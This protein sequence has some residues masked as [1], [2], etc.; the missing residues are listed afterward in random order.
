MIKK[1]TGVILLLIMLCCSILLS[2]TY[3][4]YLLSKSVNGQIELFSNCEDRGIT[5][6]AE[7]LILRDTSA[8]GNNVEA[9]KL[10]IS[11]KKTSLD[12]TA[13]DATIPAIAPQTKYVKTVKNVVN[14]EGIFSS[15]Y[16]Y[17]FSSGYTFD[18][19]TGMYTL[20][21]GYVMDYLDSKYIGYYT[22]APNAS[23]S[24]KCSEMYQVKNFEIV[25][26]SVNTIYK[27]TEADVYSY[28]T[29]ELFSSDQGL[30]ATEDNY[31]TSYY[32]RGAVDNNYVSYAGFIWKIV[33]INGD[34]S[35][36]LI[37]N[38]NSTSS[39]GVDTGIAATYFS[40]VIDDPTYVGYMYG[41]D[42]ALKE[43][44][45]ENEKSNF[46]SASQTTLYYFADSYEFDSSTEKF[47]LAGNFF[48]GT[49]PDNYEKIISDYPYTCLSLS[50]SGKCNFVVKALEYVS[51][52][53]MK[54]NYVS[55]SSKSYDS[56][57]TNTNDS[58]IKTVID[59]WYEN[60]ILN[61]KDSNDNSYSN[62]LNDTIFCNDRSLYSGDGYSLHFATVYGVRNRTGSTIYKASPS[63]ICS[64]FADKF[65]V[66]SSSGNGA[67]SYPIGLISADEAMFA[68]GLP[69]VVNENYYLNNGVTNYTMT[70]FRFYPQ[71]VGAAIMS[72]HG[73]GRVGSGLARVTRNVRPVINL[74]SDVKIISGDGMAANPF[75]ISIN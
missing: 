24:I 16:K 45:S 67:L 27:L 42:F 19:Y 59:S 75:I 54:A 58:Y 21:S 37:Y 31:G 18:E 5:N 41:K 44:F 71:Y 8:N 35:I 20:N 50:K 23:V 49:W 7:C 17:T 36:R 28:K 29:T 61:V 9:A 55:Y 48:R 70:P 2:K 62:Y 51:N 4:K 53:T 6:L 1:F 38:G 69:N 26:S 65:T 13:D 3:S 39:T 15:T 73:D 14:S 40:D 60:N 72:I 52:G 34:G 57:L 32:Y 22:C 33:R 11:N 47:N 10:A 63:L 46:I 30:Y 12:T 74:K 64:Q 43:Q 25:N 56:T 68:G 66:S